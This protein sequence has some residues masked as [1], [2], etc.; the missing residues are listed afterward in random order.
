MVPSPKILTL[1]PMVAFVLI[2]MLGSSPG[3][4]RLLPLEFF[5]RA[6]LPRAMQQSHDKEQGSSQHLFELYRMKVDGKLV[7]TLMVPPVAVLQ[8]WLI[9]PLPQRVQ[10]LL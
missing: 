4:H 8:L 2:R 7:V 10:L 6:H 1:D 5:R 9:P 3:N